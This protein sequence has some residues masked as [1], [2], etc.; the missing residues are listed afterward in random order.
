M[1]INNLPK[2][3]SWNQKMTAEKKMWIYKKANDKGVYEK[4]HDKY[5]VPFFEFM[6]AMTSDYENI[7]NDQILQLE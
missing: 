7:C 1:K 6:K 5:K 3:T 2:T 4:F